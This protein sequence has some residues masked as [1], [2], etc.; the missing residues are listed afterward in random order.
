MYFGIYPVLGCSIATLVYVAV[1]WNE[2]WAYRKNL[3]N[4]NQIKT[5]KEVFTQFIDI[6]KRLTSNL[7]G[8]KAR[9]QLRDVGI[10]ED[11]FIKQILIAPPIGFI[12]GTV[13]AMALKA[14]FN[15][16]IYSG[17]VFAFIGLI[18]TKIS[19][20]REIR[21]YRKES[22]QA[23]PDWINIL[24]INIIA[25]DTVEHAVW[26]SIPF[27]PKAISNRLTNIKNRCEGE[28][29]FTNSLTREINSTEE[30]ELLTIYNQIKAYHVTGIPDSERQNVFGNMSEHMAKIYANKSEAEIDGVKGPIVFLILLAFLRLLV[31]LGTPILISLMNRLIN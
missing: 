18:L 11:L 1:F 29:D 5:L 16:A 9:S 24:K 8:A 17:L 30:S 28:M 23:S 3:F 19:L 21:I 10:D 14:P 13:L 31:S 7:I 22:I 6:A 2:G 4:P 26:N 20:E 27:V 25:G 15:K 12:V